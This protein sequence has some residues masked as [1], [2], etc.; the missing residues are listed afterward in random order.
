MTGI[1][2]FEAVEQSM[3]NAIEMLYSRDANLLQS[4]REWA[5]AH[6][7]A[8]YMEAEFEGWNVD[9]EYNR[10]G[11][12]N[13]PKRSSR[14]AIVRPDIIVHHRSKIDLIHNLLVVEI[15]Y[16]ELENGDDQKLSDFTSMPIDPRQY[17]YQYGLGVSNFASSNGPALKWFRN[18][19]T[20]NSFMF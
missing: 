8:V 1:V 13:D 5:I 15:K 11:V 19:Q 9:C 2:A 20:F 12:K 18:G 7:I 3:R 6:R 16:R 14:S 10:Q 4:G 17:Q